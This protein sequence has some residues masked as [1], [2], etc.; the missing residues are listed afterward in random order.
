MADKYDCGF[1]GKA[2]QMPYKHDGTDT[3]RICRE[4]AAELVSALARMLGE[5]EG[6]TWDGYGACVDFPTIT[7]LMEEGRDNG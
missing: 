4:C 6:L 1:C 5:D 2:W 7:R 3:G